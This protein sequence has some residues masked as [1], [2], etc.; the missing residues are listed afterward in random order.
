MTKQNT[1][2]HHA[3]IAM[4]NEYNLFR[5]FVNRPQNQI[6]ADCA[7]SCAVRACGYCLEAGFDPQSVITDAHEFVVECNRKLE[8]AA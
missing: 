8:A 4:I 2:N 5:D 3:M 6:N 1:K 7:A